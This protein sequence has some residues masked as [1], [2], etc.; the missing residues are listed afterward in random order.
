MLM[1]RMWA[2]N[3]TIKNNTVMA[4]PINEQRTQGLTCY[5]TVNKHTTTALSLEK[6]LTYE[7][8]YVPQLQ[9]FKEGLLQSLAWQPVHT[10]E[11]D[12]NPM[13][14]PLRQGR[15]AAFFRVA[16]S[17]HQRTWQPSCNHL[18]PGKALFSETTILHQKIWQKRKFVH[19]WVWTTYEDLI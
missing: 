8:N 16:T 7:G 10:K 9:H 5:C 14:T 1:R 3:D 2:Y 6:S 15:L 18:M 11:C 17:P 19:I 4:C 12:N 13:L